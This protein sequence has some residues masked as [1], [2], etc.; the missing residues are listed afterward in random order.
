[1]DLKLK[2]IDLVERYHAAQFQFVATELE[3]ATTFC[4]VAASSS[5]S[6]KSERNA[7][8]AR[9]AYVSATHFLSNA[10]LTTQQRRE[11]GGKIAR[12]KRLLDKVNGRRRTEGTLSGPKPRNRPVNPRYSPN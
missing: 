10:I 7:E 3:L 2:T 9:R 12:L 8:Q 6:H 4:H 5:N 1:M 11:I